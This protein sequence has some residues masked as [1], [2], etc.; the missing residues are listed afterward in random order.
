VNK[1]TNI[2][3]LAL[4]HL[5]VFTFP[6]AVKEIHHH[7]TSYIHIIPQANEGKLLSQVEKP[8]PICQF[9]FVS[10]ILTDLQTQRLCQPVSQINNYNP[11]QQVY[12]VPLTSYLLRAPPLA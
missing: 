12:I 8:C 1:K 9:E 2:I 10:F 7:E 4:F 11:L 3:I 6:F 5:L